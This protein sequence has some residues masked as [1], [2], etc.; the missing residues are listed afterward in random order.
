MISALGIIGTGRLAG[1]LALCLRQR[2]LRLAAVAGRSPE[3]VAVIAE[4]AGGSAACRPADIAAIA[5]HLIVAVKDDAIELVAGELQH[6]A[7]APLVALHTS[8]AAGPDAFKA[9]LARGTAIGVLHPLQTI[10]DAKT[11]AAALPGSS[12][13]YAGDPPAERCAIELIQFLAGQPL[14]IRRERWLFYHAAAVLASNYQ[15]ALVDAALELMEGAGVSHEQALQALTPLLTQTTKNVV[16]S[17]PEH[18]LTGP[19]RR[20]DAH[21]VLGHIQ[22]LRAATPDILNLYAAA[23]RQT[24]NLAAR[25]GLDPVYVD[26]VAKAL[27]QASTQ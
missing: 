23:G 7:V 10:P 20:G 8:G 19:I 24:L 21:T 26:Q 5:T 18:A 17:G 13:A 9:L 11:G 16:T 6:A 15:V 27:A 12:W 22:A 3:A 2:G 14:P 1:A 4:M 25:C